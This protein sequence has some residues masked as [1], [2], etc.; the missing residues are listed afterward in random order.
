[1]DLTAGVHRA[2]HTW[3]DHSVL[4]MVWDSDDRTSDGRAPMRLIRP[5]QVMLPLAACLLIY[6]CAD[7][8][9]PLG[10][11][12]AVRITTAAPEPQDPAEVL[13]ASVTG[14]VLTLEMRYGGG[15]RDHTFGLFHEGV[16][17]ES[18][19]PQANLLMS[20]DADEDPCDALIEREIAFDLAP[21]RELLQQHSPQN[22][23]LV[24]N[25]HAPGTDQV[26]SVDY[27]F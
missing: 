20:H 9:A 6:A 23:M 7:P 19:P 26:V 14:D 18:D 17:L 12:P 27:R 1:M 22:E 25:V 5:L 2:C 10:D 3:V 21:L 13:G 15:C 4:W 11:P 8:L 24:L 16:F